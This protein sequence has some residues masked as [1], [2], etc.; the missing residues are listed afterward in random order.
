MGTPVEKA[1][2]KDSLANPAALEYFV[3]LSRELA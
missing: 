3:E 2:S 1:A